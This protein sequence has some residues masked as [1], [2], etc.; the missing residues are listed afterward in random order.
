MQT[1]R[2]KSSCYLYMPTNALRE[3][4]ASN[5]SKAKQRE[6][7]G[8]DSSQEAYEAICLTAFLC[9]TLMLIEGIL[10]LKR[11]FAETNIVREFQSKLMGYSAKALKSVDF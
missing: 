9:L 6:S 5:A 1:L 4:R 11:Y 8:F 2:E 10:S 7:F 3:K